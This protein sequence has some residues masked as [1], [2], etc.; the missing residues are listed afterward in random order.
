MVTHTLSSDLCFASLRILPAAT[1]A[2]CPCGATSTAPWRYSM[3][4]VSGR[5][6]WHRDASRDARAQPACTAINSQDGRTRSLPCGGGY[7]ELTRTT[8]DSKASG[9]QALPQCCDKRP[10]RMPSST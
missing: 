9:P 5:V 10:F 3:R 2:S 6:G 4:Q 1:P 8:R 7:C